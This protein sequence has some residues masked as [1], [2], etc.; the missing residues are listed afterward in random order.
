[1]PTITKH[2][3][4][5]AD[6]EKMES[7]WS[8]FAPIENVSEIASCTDVI[9]SVG[10]DTEPVE[11]LSQKSTIVKPAIKLIATIVIVIIFFI[12]IPSLLWII[13]LM[14]VKARCRPKI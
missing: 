8:P 6:P 7:P 3:E 4:R 13:V 10:F 2:K 1:M 14:N 11:G 12:F 5:I 9:S